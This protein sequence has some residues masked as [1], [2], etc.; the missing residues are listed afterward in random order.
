MGFDRI[1]PYDLT[2]GDLV[3]AAIIVS[4]VTGGRATRWKAVLFLL[5]GLL[6]IIGG[7]VDGELLTAAFG[8]LFLLLI[9]VI[10]PA[11]RSRKGSRDIYLEYGPDGLIAETTN[12]RTTYK[13]NTIGAVRKIGSRLFIMISDGCALVVSDRLTSHENMENLMGTIAHHKMS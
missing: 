1:G 6:L 11:F 7:F 5:V 4:F 13:W 10:G 12:V 9:F 2:R 8:L 3:A